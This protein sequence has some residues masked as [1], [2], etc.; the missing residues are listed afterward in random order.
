MMTREQKRI[1]KQAAWRASQG[2]PAKG[3]NPA[4]IAKPRKVK[5]NRVADRYADEISDNLG[6][7]ADY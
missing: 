2:L 6:L 5:A 1:A 7:S 4:K 3:G